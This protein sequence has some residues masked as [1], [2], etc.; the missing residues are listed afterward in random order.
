MDLKFNQPSL[1]DTNFKYFHNRIKPNAIARQRRCRKYGETEGQGFLCNQCNMPPLIS[2]GRR[3]RA[4]YLRCNDALYSRSLSFL[5]HF[6]RPPPTLF[7]LFR[8]VTS[9]SSSSSLTLDL[10]F[11]TRNARE[12]ATFFLFCVFSAP[13]S[14]T[15][16]I[17][18]ASRIRFF[19]WLFFN[20]IAAARAHHF[21]FTQ[22]FITV[23]FEKK[24]Q[25]KKLSCPL[26]HDLSLFIFRVFIL[27]LQV[28]WV[29]FEP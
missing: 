12:S 18:E 17:E 5:F 16:L 23:S 14:R 28:W 22:S 1:I 4:H 11:C 3:R 6:I 9:S 29:N 20:Q 21:I 24:K 7:L 8:G 25:Q 19:K 2:R 15:P 26:Q 13:S 27:K 10:I